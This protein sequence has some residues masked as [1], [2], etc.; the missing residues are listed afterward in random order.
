MA[1]E[2]AD[3]FSFVP[4]IIIGAG[5]SGTNILRDT[6]CRLDGFATWDCDEINPIWR[7]GNLSVAHDEFGPTEARPAVRN[8]IREQFRKAWRRLGRPRYLVEKT[9]ANSL[10]V[11]FVDA[12]LPEA[13]Y[14]FIY[15]D[16]VDVVASAQKRWRGEMEVESLPYYWA[17][18]RNTP[19]RDLPVYAYRF[20]A[21]R[22]SMLLGRSQHL[23]SWGPRFKGMDRL[24]A[25]ATL[26]ELCAHQWSKCV[27]RSADAFAE[28]PPEK[29]VRIRYESLVEDPDAA[30][31][32][33]LD[34]LGE[35]TDR[36]A[37]SEATAAVSRRSVGRGRR[38]LGAQ[39][40]QLMAIMKEPLERLG[41]GKDLP[42]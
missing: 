8:F 2:N 41:Y 29:L 1:A 28:M 40:N 38:S 15:R 42:A 12:V 23:S 31:S 18:A 6:L 26:D 37:I 20:I 25:A 9:C 14:V 36:R 19:L 4:L 11:P 35:H 30:V 34:F 17:K 13:R 21:T 39:A 3:A 5:R 22:V 24:A 27:E 32:K 33:I 10:R 16:G 7:H